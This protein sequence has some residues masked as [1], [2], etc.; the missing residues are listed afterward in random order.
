MA[1]DTVGIGVSNVARLIDA[2]WIGVSNV[3]RDVDEIWIG[4]T[5]GKAQLVWKGE[6]EYRILYI[7]NTSRLYSDDKGVTWTVYPDATQIRT[8]MYGKKAAYGNGIVVCPAGYNLYYSE[9]GGATWTKSSTTLR[10]NGTTSYTAV[11]F[12]EKTG[13]FV[14][15][16]ISSYGSY[17][18]ITDAYST[19]GKTWTVNVNLTGPSTDSTIEYKPP[20]IDADGDVRFY[21]TDING[22]YDCI[23][24]DGINR[25]TLY[26]FLYMADLYHNGYYYLAGSKRVFYSTDAITWTSTVV[27]YNGTYFPYGKDNTVIYASGAQLSS[28][29]YLAGGLSDNSEGLTYTFDDTNVTVYVVKNAFGMNNEYFVICCEDYDGLTRN[30]FK[31]DDSTMTAKIIGSFESSYKGQNASTRLFETSVLIPK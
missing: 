29:S 16:Q 8:S 10:T 28:E 27:T 22:N 18:Y 5:S 25:I 24:T 31:L 15:F 20:F 13:Y 14:A 17:Y 1:K 12:C 7:T 21:Y 6:D 2:G 23:K 3:A 9:D 19:D 26:Q 4:D 30:V 11:M